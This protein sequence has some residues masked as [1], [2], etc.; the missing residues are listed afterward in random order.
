MNT[1]D[2]NLV[3]ALRN[4]LPSALE[5]LMDRYGNGVYGLVSRVMAGAGRAER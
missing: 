1:E 4:E 3:E 5:Q 2:Q